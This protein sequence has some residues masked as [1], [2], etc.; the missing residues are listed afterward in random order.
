V[1]VDLDLQFGDAATALLLSP[2]HTMSDAAAVPAEDLDAATLKVFLTRHPPSNLF[3]LCAP[4]DPALGDAI[5]ADTV[6]RI[7][8]VLSTEFRI[9]VIDTDAGF[10]EQTLVALE[11]STDIVII[12][13]LDVPSVRGG[14]KLLKTLDQL[15]LGAARRHIILNRSDSKVGLDIGEVADVLGATIDIAVPST[16]QAPLSFNE[17]RPLVTNYAKTPI[18]KRIVELSERFGMDH[19]ARRQ[20]TMRLSDRIKQAQGE[21]DAAT[22]HDP[23]SRRRVG[24]GDP[25]AEYKQR[26]QDALY[27]RLGP[28]ALES[29]TSVEAMRK[30][31]VA[32][33][34]RII[35]EEGAPLSADERE[36]IARDVSEDVLGFGPVNRFLAD[37]EVTEIMVNG[38]DSIFVEQHGQ[39]RKTR[40]RFATE[41]Q[42]RRV[43]D[44]IV[45]QV[46]R[47]IDESSPMVDARLP[48]GS[49]VNA[50]IPPLSVDGPALTIRKFEREPFT[51]DD[52]VEMGTLTDRRSSTS[53]ALRRGSAQHPHHRGNRHRQD[54]AAQR[55]V[56]VHPGGPADR[57]H[58]GRRGTPTRPGA[59]GPPREPPAQHRGQG[60]GDRAR[61]GAQRPAHAARSDRRRRGAR[62]RGPRH[63]PGDEH[64]P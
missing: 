64:R 41:Q 48:D 53:S 62:A 36:R 6:G 59:R 20:A 19:S 60:R 46:G 31:V 34:E 39:L 51:A 32:E 58:R 56:V 44:R 11:R 10:D 7:L 54:H 1:L 13:D 40:S 63:A 35:T 52:L 2:V 47:R 4:E 61:P 21:S 55:R 38:T 30:A 26:V 45:S 29:L 25:L 5:S 16:R 37:P 57:H 42:L 50:I 28:E 18:A 9:V 43:I 27:E 15:G 22:D 33:I 49:R 17:G 12:V 14:R 8:D 24:A 3:V 23:T